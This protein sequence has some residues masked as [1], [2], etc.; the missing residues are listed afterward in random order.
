[1]QRRGLHI[2]VQRDAGHD[3][4]VVLILLRDHAVA[5]AVLGPEGDED[6]PLHRRQIARPRQRRS[7]PGPDHAAHALTIRSAAEGARTRDIR[8]LLAAGAEHPPVQ[9]RH[10]NAAGIVDGR[11][12]ERWKHVVPAQPVA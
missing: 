10:A 11:N 2:D 3:A 1:M 7:R 4:A 9:L 8:R 12:G 5:G 6:R